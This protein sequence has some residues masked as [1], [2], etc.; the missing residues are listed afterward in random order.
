[1]AAEQI[2]VERSRAEE[3][4]PIDAA[5]QLVEDLMTPRPLVYWAD[6]LFHVAL[7]W[8][9]FAFSVALPPF[10]A[11]QL[12]AFIVA[13]LA[14]YRSVLFIHE[15]AHRK[16]GTFG[17]FR[18]VWNL[19]CGFPL[20]V[21]SFLYA[22]V[23]NDH[24]AMRIY[25][26][27]ADGEYVPFGAQSPRHIV[28][29]I[30]LI[31][32]LPFLFPLRFIV[33]GPLSHLHPKLRE[34]T[35]QGFSSLAIDFNYRRPPPSARE[36]SRWRLQELG[37]F[38]Y[39]T[40]FVT[41]L[42]TG[43]LP[44]R[45]AILWYCA[46]LLVFLLNSLRTLAAHAYRNASN[47]GMNLSEQFFDSVDVPGNAFTT[48]LWAPVGLRYH[49]THHLFPTMPYHSLGEAY[50]RLARGL[51]QDAHFRD[52]SRASLWDALERL[53]RNAESSSA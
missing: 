27:R 44:F 17:R 31:F 39:G 15:L 48:P 9:A 12:V 26:T 50:R 23:H 46:V 20:M 19:T 8:S 7:G 11:W 4:F 47:R 22:R 32:A 35:W 36:G 33:A 13:S 49:A 29:Y 40:T 53:W 1:V 41:L 51:P 2:V 38:L 16:P 25:G 14:L 52:A 5:R 10:S 43:V 45:V 18:L 37:A 6:F 21:P 3:T 30:L 24:H 28:S 34:L 42:A